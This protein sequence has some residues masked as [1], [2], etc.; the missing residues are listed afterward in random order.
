MPE[1]RLPDGSV[2]YY[3]NSITVADA[4]YYIGEGLARAEIAGKVDDE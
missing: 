4:E 1:I 3:A 2:R